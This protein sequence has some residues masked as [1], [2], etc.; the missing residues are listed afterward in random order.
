[1]ALAGDT[2]QVTSAEDLNG[3]NYTLGYAASDDNVPM[4]GGTARWGQLRDSDPFVGSSSGRA[5]PNFAVA[6]ELTVP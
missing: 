5:Q 1:M 3:G 6:F 2:V 4:P